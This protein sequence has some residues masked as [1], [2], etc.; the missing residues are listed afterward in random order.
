MQHKHLRFGKGFRISLR[1]K[2]AQSA[3]MVIPPGVMT[4]DEAP[5]A[6]TIVSLPST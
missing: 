1:N 6:S 2:R 4:M 5:E 3:E